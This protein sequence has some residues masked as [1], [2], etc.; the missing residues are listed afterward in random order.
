MPHDFDAFRAAGLAY[1]G[2]PDGAIEYVAEQTER[3][4]ANYLCADVAFGDIA[5]EEAART[6]ELFAEQ[7]MPAFS[8]P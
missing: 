8:G 4:G 1:A 7:V 6:V 2:T 3:A 5:F